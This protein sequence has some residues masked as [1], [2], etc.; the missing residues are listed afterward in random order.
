MREKEANSRS[1]CSRNGSVTKSWFEWTASHAPCQQ[2]QFIRQCS[3]FETTPF[4]LIGN[5][6]TRHLEMC[7]PELRADSPATIEFSGMVSSRTAVSRMV[8]GTAILEYVSGFYYR[9]QSYSQFGEDVHIL[10]YYDRLASERNI[11]VDTGCIVDIG[12]F[13]PITFSNSYLFYKKGWY[14]INIDPTPGSKRIFDK[15]RPR[16]T[17]LELAISPVDGSSTFFLFGTPSVW[18]TLDADSA[19]FASRQTGIK[20]HEVP[21]TLSRLDTVLDQ[22]LQGHSFEI[23]SIDAEGLDIEIINANDFSRYKPR[24][25]LVE[26]M[27]ATGSTLNDTPVAKALNALGY[28]LYSWINPSLMFVRKDSLLSH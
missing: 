1:S 2:R 7:T 14:G 18:N 11:R 15:V 10:S 28:E 8:K 16:D 21:V 27:D 12:A 20:P 17:N 5:Q 22:H 6:R 23:L 13:R 4:V 25:V 9:K 3:E 19:A 24:V 26:V